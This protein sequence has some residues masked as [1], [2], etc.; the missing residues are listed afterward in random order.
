MNLSENRISN[1][2]AQVDVRG[3][4]DCWNWTGWK[5]KEG[6]GRLGNLIA[7]RVSAYLAGMNIDGLFVCHRCDNPSCVNPLHLFVGTHADNTRDRN[8]KGRDA[9]GRSHG[10]SKLT[11]ADVLEI[12]ALYASGKWTYKQLGE[13]YAVDLSNIASI[14]HRKTW[15]HL[16]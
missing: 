5:V 2:W 11:D 9:R 1:F 15:K 14:V 13:R 8:Q 6:Y 10:M 4:N 7:P 12:R 3:E 16:P